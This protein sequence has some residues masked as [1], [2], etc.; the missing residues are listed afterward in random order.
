MDDLHLGMPRLDDPARPKL[1]SSSLRP[2]RRRS[3]RRLSLRCR[4]LR[5]GSL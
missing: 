3:L 5:R 2:L 4:S 1:T